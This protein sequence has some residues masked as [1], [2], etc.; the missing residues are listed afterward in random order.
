[1]SYDHDRLA[2][3]PPPRDRRGV[4]RALAGSSRR[5]EAL[6]NL[7]TLKLLVSGENSHHHGICSRGEEG[8]C[9]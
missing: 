9:C 6:Q 1:M 7:H 4:L 8:V 3:F 5:S 2:F